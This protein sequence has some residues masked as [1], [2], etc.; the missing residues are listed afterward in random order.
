LP[1]AAVGITAALLAAVPSASAA[2][3]RAAVPGNVYSW[4]VNSLGE[5][6]PALPPNTNRPTP[7]LVS[8]LPG[9][10]R[11]LVTAGGAGTGYALLTDGTVR[12]WGSNQAGNLGDGTHT[13]RTTPVQVLNLSSITQ[14]AGGDT[15]FGLALDAGGAVWGWGFNL[16]GQLGLGDFTSRLQPVQVP[17][18]SG[19]AQ[20]AGGARHSLAL[21]SDGTVWAWGQ[22]ASG[23]LGDGTTTLRRPTPAQVQGLTGVV[24]VAAGD[25]LSVA[26]RADGTVWTWGMNVVGEL[27]L[28]DDLAR[29][30]PTQVPGLTDVTQIAAGAGTVLA[31]TS[32]GSVRGWGANDQGEVGNGTAAN[33]SS[34]VLI[35]GL[36]AITQVAAN[37]ERSSALSANGTLRSW[38]HNDGISGTLGVGSTA[39][40]VFTPMP[41][42]HW[43]GGIQQVAMTWSGTLVIATAPPT[44]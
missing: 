5:I 27:G 16:H 33:V 24:Q 13:A 6:D 44:P 39:T 43:S 34:P 15:G 40:A 28:G 14:I 7:A 22:N 32:N 3:P 18:L 30:V 26:L 36:S 9:G 29:T 11:Q 41:V 38:G 25:E 8:G 10:V 35:V 21:R 31:L 4:G 42:L 17:G 2:V 19:F 12:S 23:E 20:V 37:G 1:A